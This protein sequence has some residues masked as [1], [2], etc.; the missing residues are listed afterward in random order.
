M[1]L[2]VNIKVIKKKMC[3][4]ILFT[5]NFLKI[6]QEVKSFLVFFQVR[7]SDNSMS[8]FLIPL[9]ASWEFAPLYQ[10]CLWCLQTS[11]LGF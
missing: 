2:P 9:L 3:D 5:Q 6:D 10:A 7:F 11:V 4:T 1:E 8:K